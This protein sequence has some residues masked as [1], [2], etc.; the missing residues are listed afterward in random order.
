[1]E[2]RPRLR[3]ID[4]QIE[5]RRL[6]GPLLLA[7]QPGEALRK[8]IGYAKVHV[9][10][11]NSVSLQVPTPTVLATMLA[12]GKLWYSLRIADFQ[13]LVDR[14][15]RSRSAYA[16]V[17][18]A[19]LMLRRSSSIALTSHPRRCGS[20]RS[21]GDPSGHAPNQPGL[22]QFCD[23]SLIG[24]VVAEHVVEPTKERGVENLEM[25]SC[26]DHQAVGALVLDHL[27]KA[28]GIIDFSKQRSRIS[29]YTSQLPTAR[30]RLPGAQ[31]NLLTCTGENGKPCNF[32][33]R[34]S[35]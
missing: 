20:E 26:G 22:K 1:M 3:G 25:V 15:R 30:S 32:I 13:F 6:R 5:R 27:E 14:S 34:A 16:Q 10:S 19:A 7:I 18:S 17:A 12:T 8:G 24:Q 33:G 11:R 21:P 31:V 2:L 28:V 35:C 9:S 23:L 4:L 29:S